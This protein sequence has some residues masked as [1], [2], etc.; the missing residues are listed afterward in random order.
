MEQG[1]CLQ[2]SKNHPLVVQC[3]RNVQLSGVIELTLYIVV[4]FTV[5]E[6]FAETGIEE[7]M[8]TSHTLKI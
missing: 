3:N 8:E 2:V 1:S 6:A 4:L 7:V 5:I